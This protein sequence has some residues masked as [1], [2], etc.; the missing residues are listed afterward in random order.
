MHA[1]SVGEGLQA[2]AVLTPLRAAHPDWQIVYTHT[3]PSAEALAARQPADLAGY[4][5]WDR[6]RDLEPALQALK[7]RALVFAKLDLWP[8]LATRA[9]AWG[10]RVGMIAATVSPGS[11]RL[12]WP[13]RALLRAGYAVV[14]RAGAIAA[15]HADRLALLGVDRARIEVTGDPRFDSARARAR[16]LAHDD[17]LVRL[18]AGAPTLVAGSTWPADEALLLPAFAAIR[19]TRP[20]ARLILVPHEPTADHLASIERAAAAQGLPA[21]V[22]LSAGPGSAPLVVVD[23]TGL[24]A[25]LYAAGSFA[26]VGGGYGRAGLH[27]VLEPAAC[28]LPVLFGPNWQ[29]SR[30]AGLLLDDDGAIAVPRDPAALA[31]V[32]NTW[33]SNDE[34]R[35]DAGARALE[36]VE[37]GQGAAARNAALVRGLMDSEA[38]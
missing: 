19:R 3:S 30:E 17:P 21:P 8:E 37:Q 31:A 24:L 2:E 7:P 15:D 13:T 28:G 11:S 26:Y 25:R 36:V 14:A 20:M 18:G 22:R 9:A 23:S 38:A 34:E 32:W 35:R 33:M 6:A 5:P 1:P 4:L 27:S 10:T 16:S 29:D 12:R